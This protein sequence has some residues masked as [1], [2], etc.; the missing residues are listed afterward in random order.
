MFIAALLILISS[1]SVNAVGFPNSR[2]VHYIPE[3]LR[4]VFKINDGVDDDHYLRWKFI[5]QSFGGFFF[6]ARNA[7]CRFKPMVPVDETFAEIILINKWLV[8]IG[9]PIMEWEKFSFG[10]YLEHSVYK[11]VSLLDLVDLRKMLFPVV[12]DV[13]YYDRF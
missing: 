5:E 10:Y 1:M 8:T 13:E 12:R 11:M 6:F 2:L 4:M 7:G 3:Y 9:K